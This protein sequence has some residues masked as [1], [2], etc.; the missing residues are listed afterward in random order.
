MSSFY[1]A[2]RKKY[3]MEQRPEYLRLTAVR[4]IVEIIHSKKANCS[5]Y[6]A[7][8]KHSTLENSHTTLDK[9]N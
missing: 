5:V 9:G 2:G 6:K 1:L 7:L 4:K 3:A 8:I